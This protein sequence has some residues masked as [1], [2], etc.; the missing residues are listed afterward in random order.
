MPLGSLVGGLLFLGLLF[1]IV[2]VV[3]SAGLWTVGAFS[4][5]YNQAQNGKRGFLIFSGLAVSVG[6]AYVAMAWAESVGF[7]W[8]LQTLALI[9]AVSASM[10]LLLLA[11][12]VGRAIVLR[13]GATVRRL[14]VRGPLVEH[15]AL[16][17]ASLFIPSV[18]RADW[19][20]ESLSFLHEAGPER[21]AWLWD[22]VWK[23]P[24][25]GAELGDRAVVARVITTSG[26]LV[27]YGRDPAA[28]REKACEVMDT[29]VLSRLGHAVVS[30]LPVLGVGA[31]VWLYEGW[32]AVIE[33]LDNVAVVAAAVQ[34][35][36]IAVRRG[37]RRRR[38]ARSDSSR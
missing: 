34:A 1:L 24:L 8:S 7:V 35:A 21:R 15:F 11:A 13:M 16:A 12:K 18:V 27:E 3:L 33:N 37:A 38:A 19:W 2:A 5:H 23:A 31:T 9:G 17:A 4:N 36:L 26:R 22:L 14:R 30:T 10:L 28:L 32:F 25:T 29:V 6:A 20:E